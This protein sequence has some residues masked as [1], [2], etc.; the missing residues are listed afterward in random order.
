MKEMKK[1]ISAIKTEKKCNEVEDF[2]QDA[3]IAE[4]ISEEQ[5]FELDKALRLQRMKIETKSIVA[6][7]NANPNTPTVTHNK[8]GKKIKVD[9]I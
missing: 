4:K 5:Y 1:L 3:M 8:H 2:L 6:E 9:K 7:K